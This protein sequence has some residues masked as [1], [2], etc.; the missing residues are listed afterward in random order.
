MIL[1]EPVKTEKAIMM[2]DNDNAITFEVRIDATRKQILE[3]VE[4][5]FSVKVHSVRT[6]ITPAGKKRA[7]VRLNK[8]HKADEIAA[9]LKIAA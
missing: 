4:K 6:Y 5:L 2:I 3:E 1:I 7:V 9:K 8:E